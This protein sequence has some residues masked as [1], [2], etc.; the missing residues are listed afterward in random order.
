MTVDTSG[1]HTITEIANDKNDSTLDQTVPGTLNFT[2]VDLDDT[3]TVSSSLSSATWSSGGAL[4]SGLSTV[5]AT[6]LSTTVSHDSTGS[7]AGSVGFTFSAADKNFDFLAAGETLT[8]TYDVTVKD[9]QNVTS[10]QPVTVVITGSEDAPVLTV[11]TSGPHTITEI[12]NDKNNSTLDQTV[13]GTLNFTDVDLDDTHTVSSSLSSATWSSGGALPSGLSTVL[14]TALSTTVSH[15]STGSGAGSVGFTFS[16]ADKNF[17]FLAAG[18]TL[19]LTYDVTVKD[20]QNVTSTQPVTVVI[21]GTND[22]PVMAPDASGPHLV[23]ER[24]GNTGDTLD[25]DTVS[26]TLTFTDVDLTDTHTVGRSL[27]SAVWSG[28]S[29]MP[30]GLTA[31]LE[32]ALATTEVDSTGSG[33]G[34]VGFTFSAADN[35]FDFLAAGETLIV[36]YNVSVINKLGSTSFIAFQPITITITGTNDAPVLSVDH[37]YNVQDQFSSQAYN[38]NTGSVAWATNWIETN[39]P[40]NN[41]AT[42]GDIQIAGGQSDV[43]PGDGDSDPADRQSD[44]RDRFSNFD[45]RLSAVQL[46]PER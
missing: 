15:D 12:A 22:V 14:A 13:P 40:A 9:S 21:T 46:G 17:D 37:H 42:T 31:V 6:A 27:I 28:G 25:L 11:D 29:T 10:T 38:L 3:H 16:A 32:G 19:T 33:A 24:P 30:N 20:S 45:L 34:S 39:E 41:A 35:N 26:G 5:L 43:L 44:G 7:G 1:P 36:T 23:T 8:L 4:P 18:E 2:D